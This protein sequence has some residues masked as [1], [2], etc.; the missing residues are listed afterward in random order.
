MPGGSSWENHSDRRQRGDG[1]HF[2]WGAKAGAFLVGS[3]TKWSLARYCREKEIRI[4]LYLGPRYSQG[5]KRKEALER[6]VDFTDLIP[7]IEQLL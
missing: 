6:D 3:M 2:D 7:K 5:E 1:P 4:N